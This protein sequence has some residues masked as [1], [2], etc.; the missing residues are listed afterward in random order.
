MS[1]AALNNRSQPSFAVDPKLGRWLTTCSPSTKSG[2][3]ELRATMSLVFGVLLIIFPFIASG[4]TPGDEKGAQFDTET[5]KRTS[6]DRRGLYLFSRE[7]QAFTSKRT[8]EN[9]LLLRLLGTRAVIE[10]GTFSKIGITIILRR[11][12]RTFSSGWSFHVPF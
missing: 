4:A 1:T 9:G 6:F 10:T 7:R 2:R 11:N 5:K 3:Y 8:S 12:W